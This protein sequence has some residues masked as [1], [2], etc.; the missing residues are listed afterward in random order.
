MKQNPVSV[1][2]LHILHLEHLYLVFVMEWVLSVGTKYQ[3]QNQYEIFKHDLIEEFVIE[4]MERFV[5]KSY[6]QKGSGGLAFKFYKE[7]LE[8][9]VNKVLALL[10]R[11]L[12]K[13]IFPH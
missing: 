13:D 8:F 11:G 9:H 10:F 6:Q 4:Y 7:D 3:L 12:L 1:E 5:Q 2:E